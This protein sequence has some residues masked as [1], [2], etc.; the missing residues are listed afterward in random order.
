MSCVYT[1]YSCTCF[2]FLLLSSTM[3]CGNENRY[4]LSRENIL[5]ISIPQTTL[6]YDA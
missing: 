5:N 6:L 3:M 1:V 2:H 4:S